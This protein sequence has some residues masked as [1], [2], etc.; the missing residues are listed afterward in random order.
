MGADET[1]KGFGKIKPS[2][3]ILRDMDPDVLTIDDTLRF[4]HF[5]RPMD[6]LWI[7]VIDRAPDDKDSDTVYYHFGLIID[8]RVDPPAARPTEDDTHFLDTDIGAPTGIW[9][10][11]GDEEARW[12]KGEW[13]FRNPVTASESGNCYMTH[14]EDATYDGLFNIIYAICASGETGKIKVEAI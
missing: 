9:A 10:G 2:D 6:T 4:M 7:K 13:V 8:R 11:H 3:G 1:R 14:G 5:D 12:V